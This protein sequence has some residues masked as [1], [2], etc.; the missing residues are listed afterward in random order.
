MKLFFIASQALNF[1]GKFIEDLNTHIVDSLLV[2]F[3]TNNDV[4]ICS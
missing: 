1:G 3:Y 2:C 4:L